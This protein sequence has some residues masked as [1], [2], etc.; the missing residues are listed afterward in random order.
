MKKKK[1][2]SFLVN[3]KALDFNDLFNVEDSEQLTFSLGLDFVD[4]WFC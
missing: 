4:F 1:A 2:S 3:L